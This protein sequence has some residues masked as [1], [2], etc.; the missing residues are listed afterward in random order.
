M[1]QNKPQS[2]PWHVYLLEL[3]GQIGITKSVPNTPWPNQFNRKKTT[4]SNDAM[5]NA[6]L[7]VLMACR[8]FVIPGG[9]KCQRKVCEQ[10]KA[11]AVKIG[12][13]DICSRK[14]FYYSMYF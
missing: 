11:E 7:K 2:L 9:E 5:F 13:A 14:P 6:I 4:D 10:R 3:V 8:N 12:Y 1:P